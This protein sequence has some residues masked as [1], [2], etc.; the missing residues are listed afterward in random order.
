MR[1]QQL[2]L[3]WNHDNHDDAPFALARITDPAADADGR[4]ERKGRLE[5]QERSREVAAT[6]PAKM[7]CVSVSDNGPVDG[8]PGVDEKASLL[9]EQANI[10]HT[11]QLAF[12]QA[13]AIVIETT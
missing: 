6:S 4:P 11:K 5:D 13:H 9:A 1:S 8:P 2:G 10:R 12:V 7:V 3:M